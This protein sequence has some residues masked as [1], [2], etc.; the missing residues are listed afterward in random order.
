MQHTAVISCAAEILEFRTCGNNIIDSAA[1]RIARCPGRRK[2]GLTAALSVFW[3]WDMDHTST[4][5]RNTKFTHFEF[6][7]AYLLAHCHAT[8]NPDKFRT[9]PSKHQPPAAQ[10]SGRLYQPDA[11]TVDT[12]LVAAL[13]A[14]TAKTRLWRYVSAAV[15]GLMQVIYH[16]AIPRSNAT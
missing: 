3:G 2:S 7:N 5:T 11:L 10:I 1:F 13:T 6:I 8:A 9:W 4:T 14:V 12:H 16:A 15:P